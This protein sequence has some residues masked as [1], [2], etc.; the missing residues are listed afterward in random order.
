MSCATRH[1][2]YATRSV[3]L[4]WADFRRG[5]TCGGQPCGIAVHV[6]SPY[7]RFPIGAT[8]RSF[9]IWR[10][11]TVLLVLMAIIQLGRLLHW[12]FYQQ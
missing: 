2:P 1:D 7:R 3:R 10:C 9:R 4:M 5:E 12:C 11:R 8:S 6:Q